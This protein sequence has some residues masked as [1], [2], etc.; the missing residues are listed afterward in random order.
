MKISL[1]AAMIAA[2]LAAA[3]ASYAT[4]FDVTITNLSNSIYYTPFLVAALIRS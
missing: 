3:P 4:D 2:S 1:C